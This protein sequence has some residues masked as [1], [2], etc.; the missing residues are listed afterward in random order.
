MKSICECRWWTGDGLGT[1]G[2]VVHIVILLPTA[3]VNGVGRSLFM[4]AVAI[5]AEA[6]N[7]WFQLLVH[8]MLADYLVAM[9]AGRY[10]FPRS[11]EKAC[12]PSRRSRIRTYRDLCANRFVH[13]E[14]HSS[15]R[16][17]HQ[18]ARPT[19]W[20]FQMDVHG[21]R[22]HSAVILLPTPALRG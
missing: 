7:D 15:K 12:R 10:F 4:H 17:D 6:N 16:R 19:K 8:G 22:T 21:F 5:I 2:F 18:S 3:A 14:F 20:H 11:G 1:V 9:H 13:Q